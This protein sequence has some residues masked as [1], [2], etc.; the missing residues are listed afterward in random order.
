MILKRKLG[1]I[2]A[3]FC[4]SAVVGSSVMYVAA[5]DLAGSGNLSLSRTQTTDISKEIKYSCCNISHLI[6]RRQQYF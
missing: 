2:R 1:P 6:L 5:S 4:D 3:L